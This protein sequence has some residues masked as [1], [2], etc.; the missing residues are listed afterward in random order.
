MEL[1]ALGKI[2]ILSPG[3]DKRWTRTEMVFVSV[4]HTCPFQHSREAAHSKQVAIVS[5][6]ALS[7]RRNEGTTLRH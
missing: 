5:A 4:I 1:G 2:G 7:Y 6:A 3:C